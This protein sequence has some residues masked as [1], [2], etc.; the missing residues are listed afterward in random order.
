MHRCSGDR[1]LG[2][3]SSIPHSRWWSRD[4]GWPGAFSAKRRTLK[5]QPLLFMPLLQEWSTGGTSQEQDCLHPNLLVLP[6]HGPAVFVFVLAG[7]GIVCSVDGAWLDHVT[8]CITTQHQNKVIFPGPEPWGLLYILTEIGV[9]GHPLPEHAHFITTEDLLQKVAYLF[10]KFS[11][12]SGN[13][14]AVWASASVD[15]PM[16]SEFLWLQHFTELASHP[17]EPQTQFSAAPH[18]GAHRG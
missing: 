2:N 17:C 5:W 10:C 8:C 13:T 1:E 16:I 18:S 6:E 7:L 15:S 9:I 12:L 14:E 11:E 4:W 3:R